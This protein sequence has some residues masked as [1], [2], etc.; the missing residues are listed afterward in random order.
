MMLAGCL[1]GLFNSWLENVRFVLHLTRLEF[2]QFYQ[3]IL[4]KLHDFTIKQF[5]FVSNLK[6]Y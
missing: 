3:F 6:Q 5:S 2:Y 1:Q 4:L